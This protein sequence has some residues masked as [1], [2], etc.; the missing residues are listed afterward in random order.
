MLALVWYLGQLLGAALGARTITCPPHYWLD[1]VRRDGRFD[2]I[3]LAAGAS[4]SDD[5][6]PLTSL[7]GRLWCR[8][9]ETAIYLDPRH[10]A[11][12]ATHSLE[13]ST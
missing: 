13:R 9:D 1:G 11:C 7:G 3:A 5:N 4:D 8:V 2:C 10:A 6:A 12:V